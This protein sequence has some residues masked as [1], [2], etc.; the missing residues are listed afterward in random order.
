MPSDKASQLNELE[1]GE[2]GCT[3]VW[4]SVGKGARGG[5]SRLEVLRRSWR[6]VKAGQSVTRTLFFMEIS[7]KNVRFAFLTPRQLPPLKPAPL[8]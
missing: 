7:K 6:V 8:R 1:R 2:V 5:H 4:M 3:G